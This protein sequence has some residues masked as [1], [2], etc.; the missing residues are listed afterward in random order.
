QVDAAVAATR[1][2]AAAAAHHVAEYVFEDVGK[3]A[4]REAV[5]AAHAALL[6]GGVAEAVVGGALLRVLEALIGLVDFLELV[7][8][9]RVAGVACGMELHGA[10]AE[11]ALQFLLVGALLDAQRFV[12]IGLHRFPWA[13]TALVL[14]GSSWTPRGWTSI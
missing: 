6:E 2:T 12:E 7:L 1:S 3:A 10:L 4:G 13:S 8:A 9:R 5:G 14:R 11:S